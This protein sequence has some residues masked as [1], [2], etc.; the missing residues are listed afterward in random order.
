MGR[1]F[2]FRKARKFKRWGNMA[3][4]FTKLGKEITIAV[5]AGGPDPGSNPRLRVLM[6]TAKKE[7]MPKDNVDRAIKRA[8]SKDYTDYKEMNYEGYGPFG[9][10]VF[11]ET[12]TDNTTRTVG[13]VRSYFNKAGGA[14]G[15]TGSLEFLFDHKCVFHILKKDGVS[16]D[17][18]ELELI[19]YGVDEL[20]E[21]EGEVILY[22]DFAQNAAIQKYLEENGY[23]ITSSE[24]VRIPNDLKDVTPEQRETIDKLI[25]RLEEDEDVQNVFHNMKESE[26]EE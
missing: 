18:L 4:V 5:K 23:E 9:I 20:E 11:V 14:L 3:R 17:D 21:D 25:E 1:A 12:A 8:S 6:Q 22:G 15:T 13:N 2:E 10:A 16:L 24:F 19:D 7:N 26:E